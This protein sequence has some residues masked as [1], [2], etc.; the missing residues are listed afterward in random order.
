MA[1]TA[2]DLRR[3]RTRV[4]RLERFEAVFQ[5]QWPRVNR[6]LIGLLGDRAEAEDLALETFWRLYRRAPR[7][8]DNLPAWLYRVATNLGLNALRARRRRASYEQ[9]AG[10]LA[11]EAGQPADPPD[12]VERAEQ[13][14]LVQAT[15][16][17]IKPQYARLLVLRHSGLSYAELAGVFGVAPGSIGTLLARAEAEFEKRYRRFDGGE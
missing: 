12:E 2:D 13:R 11:L 1:V 7:P 10:Q 5:E 9:A 3:D 14:R 16:A 8:E 17:E 6:I 4:A 15:L